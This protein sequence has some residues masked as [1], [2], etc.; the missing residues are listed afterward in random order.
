MDWEWNINEFPLS[1]IIIMG[2]HLES[3]LKIV[4]VLGWNLQ[5][6]MLRYRDIS[7]FTISRQQQY[8]KSILM[9]TLAIGHI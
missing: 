7:Y 9:K 2:D 6:D 8:S 5:T 4:L 1:N 3:L